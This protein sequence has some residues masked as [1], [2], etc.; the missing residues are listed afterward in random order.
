MVHRS[1][2][3]VLVLTCN[4]TFVM[5]CVTIRSEE[6]CALRRGHWCMLLLLFD[7]TVSCLLHA[8]HK[9]DAAAHVWAEAL[10]V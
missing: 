1:A 6:L 2:E 10:L 9:P 5:P 3:L 8:G 4:T 7:W